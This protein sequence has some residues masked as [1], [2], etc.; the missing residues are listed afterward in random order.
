ML[1]MRFFDEEVGER[2]ERSKDLEAVVGKNR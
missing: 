1:R 2:K